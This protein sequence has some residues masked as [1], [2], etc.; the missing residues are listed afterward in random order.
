M[1]TLLDLLLNQKKKEYKELDL[2]YNKDKSILEK[3]KAV[4]NEKLIS[5]NK[6]KDDLLDSI[7]KE[8]ESFNNQILE[9]KENNKVENLM[10][11]KENEFLKNKIE[12]MESTLNLILGELNGG[13]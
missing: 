3:E 1:S 4:L 8:R 6:Q 10:K 11:I 7:E 12:Q 9:I 2:E 13:N 5:T